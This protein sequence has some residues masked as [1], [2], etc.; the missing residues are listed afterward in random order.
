MP[1]M[2]QPAPQ[3]TADAVFDGGEI[4]KINLSDYKGKWVVLFFYPLD[5]TFVCP[6]EIRAYSDLSHD[7]DVSGAALLGASVDSAHAH[8]AWARHG[9]G[10]VKFPMLGDV[11][12]A[13]A[14]GFGVLA[15]S[16]VAVRATFI[17]NPEGRVMSIAANDLNVGRSARETLRLLHALQSGEL[18]ACEWQ[19]G[20]AFVAA[21]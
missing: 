17:V 19:P 11:S 16:G 6:T 2:L 3:F 21:A 13:L 12:R 1:M 15:D 14:E 10:P 7:F 9:L 18:T 20:E 8:R 4:K 5:F